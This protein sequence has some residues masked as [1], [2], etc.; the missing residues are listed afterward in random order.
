VQ[1][2][3]LLAYGVEGR[4]AEQLQE[5]ASTQRV[6]LREIR[7]LQACRNLLA[8]ARPAVLVVRLGRDVERELS[9]VG[10]V[11]ELFPDTAVIVVGDVDNPSL[12]GLAWDLGA[13]FVLFPPTPFET[14]PG[15][16]MQMLAT[17]GVDAR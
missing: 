9:L 14:L 17:P 5:L 3:Q 1:Q 11:H 6:W 10:D 4:L 16:I 13:H 8:A 12:A 2:P 15:I 7:H